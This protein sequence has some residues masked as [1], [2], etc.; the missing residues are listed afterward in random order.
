MTKTNIPVVQMASASLVPVIKSIHNLLD[1]RNKHTGQQEGL[2]PLDD[3]NT[4]VIERF[5]DPLLMTG[6]SPPGQLDYWAL[7]LA[8]AEFAYNNNNHTSIGVSPFKANYG[9]NPLYS[10]I[11]LAEQCVP[12]VAERL[13]QLA[14]VQ[15]ELKHFMEAAQEA[16][17]SQFDSRVRK[18]QEWNSGDKVW[19]DGCNISTTRRSFKL[20]HHWLGVGPFPVAS[21][22]SNSTY[23]LTLPLSMQGFHPVFHVSVLC[24]HKPD[25]I[26]HRQ[27]QT[28][29]VTVNGGDEWEVKGILESRRRGRTTQ[30]IVSWCGFGLVE[31]LWKPE[32]NLKN[33]GVQLKI[34]G[35]GGQASEDAEK[36]VTG[37]AFSH[38]VF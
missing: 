25:K 32:A 22:I 31:N 4:P 15:D 13:R 21:R 37:Q 5:S 17:K 28:E 27:R 18:T 11:S 6:G 3:R 38:W 26:A 30:Y 35:G 14:E 29:P 10:G 24:K 19:L 8:K 1:D 2:S 23:K 36:K 9:F 20:E 16:M 33:S 34:S 12:A 7:L